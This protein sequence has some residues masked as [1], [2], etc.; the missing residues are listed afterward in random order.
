MR[1][2]IGSALALLIA[3]NGVNLTHA[4]DTAKNDAHL[5]VGWY[6]EASRAAAIDLQQWKMIPELYFYG[7]L[8]GFGIG[9]VLDNKLQPQHAERLHQCLSR[10]KFSSMELQALFAKD[11]TSNRY[12]D[13]LPIA[14]ALISTILGACDI[15]K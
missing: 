4:E 11:V 1:Q 5:T 3:I 6:K 7:F 2:L 13:D 15:V 14:A 10:R 8:S 12:P 9:A